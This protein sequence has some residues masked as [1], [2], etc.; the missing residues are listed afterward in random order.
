MFR[1]ASEGPAKAITANRLGDG[2]VV[3]LG[4]AGKWVERFDEASF[5]ADGP[6]LESA[7][8]YA[9]AAHDSR[10]VVEPYAIDVL[11]E[12]GQSAPVR[13]R[14]R[15]RAL[16]PSVD[17]GIAERKRLAGSYAGSAS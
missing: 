11:T 17:Y 2:R 8:L 4:E 16:G 9:Q 13:F 15:I 6:A 10:I 14:E 1:A 5:F 3:F 12:G 7:L